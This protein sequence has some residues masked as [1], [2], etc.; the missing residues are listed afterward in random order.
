MLSRRTHRNLTDDPASFILLALGIDGS[1]EPSASRR[2]RLSLRSLWSGLV[3]VC[4][5][6]TPV[7]GQ[8]VPSGPVESVEYDGLRR[9]SRTLV[10]DIAGI[11]PGQP[12]DRSVLEAA[13]DRLLRTGRFLAVSYDIEDGTAGPRVVFRLRE[14]P[15]VAK[16]TFEGLTRYRPGQLKDNLTIKEGEPVDMFAVRDGQRAIELRYRSDGYQD[17]KVTFDEKRLEES[18]ELV[19]TIVEGGRTRLRKIE[20]TGNTTYRDRRLY[21]QIRSR[22][23]LWIFRTGEYDEEQVRGDDARVETFYRDEGFLDARVTHRVEPG[24]EPDELKLTFEVVEGT[25]YA[26]ESIEFLGAKVFSVEE[27]TTILTSRVGDFVKQPKVDADARAIQERYG[28]LGYIYARVRPIR[29]FSTTPDLVRLT[30]EITEGEQFRVG[31]VVVRG[32]ERTKDKVVRRTLNLYPPDDLF[33]L[34]EA[35]E[36]E[37]RLRESRIFSA[38]RVVPVG[39]K[40]GVRDVVMDV[41]ESEKSGDFIFGFGVTSN[42]GAIGQIVLD[43]PNFDLFDTPRSFQEF[44]RFRSFFGAGQRMRI[45]LQPGTEVSRA[46]IEFTEPYLFDRPLRFDTSLY[47]FERGRDGY[48]EERAGASVSLGKR[49]E[50]GRLQGWSGEIAVRGEVVSVEDVDLFA[51]DQIRDDKGDN[52]LTAVKGTLLLDRTDNRLV[53]TSGDRLRIAYEQVGL[54]G[55]DHHF[56]KLTGSYSWYRTLAVDARERKSVLELR[57]EGGQIL[58]D[59]PVFERFYAGGVGSIRGFEFRGVGPRDGIDNNNVGGEN[60]LLW[61]AEYSFPLYEEMVRGLFFLDAGTIDFETMRSSIGVGVR[62]TLEL[63]GPLPIELAIGIPM[64]RDSDDEEQIFSFSIG[65]IF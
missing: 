50:R 58:G 12:A 46:R 17:A 62:L 11:K 57:M 19:Y 1:R 60:M 47:L 28:E 23:A 24:D 38:A 51:S 41:T 44:I 63:F 36:A 61:G 18:G 8:S 35:R 16:I 25:R 65:S 55:G 43:L 2:F 7:M 45:E 4:F 20:F 54:L 64:T 9:L 26:I 32:N 48:D 49:F 3:W 59:A 33:N 6:F 15:T 52:F 31:D 21:R 42:N 34:T 13:V 37:K 40:P 39:D 53:P 30:F 10:E 5:L 56:G 14:R 22:T 29:V 27:L